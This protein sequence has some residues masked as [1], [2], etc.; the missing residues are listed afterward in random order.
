MT[1]WCAGVFEHLKHNLFEYL[2]LILGKPRTMP[3]IVRTAGTPMGDAQGDVSVHTHPSN[4][5]QLVIIIFVAI[6]IIAIL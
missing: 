4:T 5:S 3:S 2:Y 6:V 1:P